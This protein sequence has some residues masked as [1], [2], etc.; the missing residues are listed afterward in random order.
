MEFWPVWVLLAL[1]V[2]LVVGPV[3]IN[4]KINVYKKNK[5]KEEHRRYSEQRQIESEE[6]MKEFHREEAEKREAAETARR[7]RE[8]EERKADE[9]FIG[10][11][12]AAASGNTELRKK[13][14]S[15]SREEKDFISN[16]KLSGY[17]MVADYD[18]SRNV[19]VYY[20]QKGESKKRIF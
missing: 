5:T 9:Y 15:L 18:E 2:L 1:L 17:E 6:R 19:F 10:I 16:L 7:I 4:E 3:I 20:M 14:D 13:F 8:S 12:G 11:F